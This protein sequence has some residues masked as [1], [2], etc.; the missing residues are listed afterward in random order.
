LTHG[1]IQKTKAAAVGD[2]APTIY[3]AIEELLL[4]TTNKLALRKGKKLAFEDI[5]SASAV[6]FAGGLVDG[7]LFEKTKVT[8]KFKWFKG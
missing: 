2:I 8:A 4:V 5:D 3:S 7:S 6:R 1:L